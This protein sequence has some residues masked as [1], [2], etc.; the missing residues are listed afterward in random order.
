MLRETVLGAQRLSHRLRDEGGV[1]EGRQS[2]PEDTRLEGRYELGGGLDRKARLARA[3]R[4]GQGEQAGAVLEPRRDLGQFLVSAHERADRA[5]QVRVRDRLQGRETLRSKLED[6]DGLGEVLE[7][8][9][10]QI[11]HLDRGQLTRLLGE[12]HLAAVS[13]RRDPRPLVHVLAHV[14]LLAQ[15]RHTGMDAHAYA[16]RARGEPF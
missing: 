11:H 16:D 3:A 5:G 2:G 13:G 8:V 4:A 1:A 10:A 15:A 9:L 12:Q 14:A 6:R 7:A